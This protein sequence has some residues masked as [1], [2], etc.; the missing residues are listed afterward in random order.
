MASN[1]STPIVSLKEKSRATHWT[2]YKII[3][4]EDAA[5]RFCGEGEG[6]DGDQQR[7]N[8]QFFKNVRD[9]TLNKRHVRHSLDIHAC[10][11][12]FLSAMGTIEQLI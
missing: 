4:L 10:N 1:I 11:C 8:D 5:D 12:T 9:T 7:L 6:T 2:T 3:N